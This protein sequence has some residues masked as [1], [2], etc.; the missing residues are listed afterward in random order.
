MLIE[1]KKNLFASECITVWP[2]MIIIIKGIKFLPWKI[3][4]ENYFVFKIEKAYSLYTSEVLDQPE[5]KVLHI[6]QV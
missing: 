1:C 2:K 6:R 3:H 4:E 5:R